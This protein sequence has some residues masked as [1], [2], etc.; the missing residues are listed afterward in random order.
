MKGDEL[1]VHLAGKTVQLGE[2]KVRSVPN[3]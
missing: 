1:L 2:A 3:M